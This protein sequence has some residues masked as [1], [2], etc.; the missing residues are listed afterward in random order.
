MGRSPSE[1]EKVTVQWI[2]GQK[3]GLKILQGSSGKERADKFLKM[4]TEGPTVG[5]EKAGHGGR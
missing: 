5:M 2:D 4:L 3:N 1:L